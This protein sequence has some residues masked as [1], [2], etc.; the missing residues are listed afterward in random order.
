MIV[1]AATLVLIFV[2]AWLLILLFMGFYLFMEKVWR[3][4]TIEINKGIAYF[5]RSYIKRFDE[6]VK[7]KAGDLNVKVSSLYRDTRQFWK[8]IY[9]IARGNRAN[10][11][12]VYVNGSKDPETFAEP[13]VRGD[14][15]KIAKESTAINSAMTSTFRG[16]TNTTLIVILLLGF[17]ALML[18]VSY[19]SSGG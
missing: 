5:R 8:L 15:I 4:E 13:E 12:S 19:F 18:V 3:L 14:I 17:I 16:K 7:G 6:P 1:N 9:Y 2:V 11:V 10:L